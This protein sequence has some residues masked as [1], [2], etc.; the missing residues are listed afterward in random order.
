[1][2]IPDDMNDEAL[3]AV[4]PEDDGENDEKVKSDGEIAIGGKNGTD[5]SSKYKWDFENSYLIII[6]QLFR[7]LFDLQRSLICNKDLL[8]HLNPL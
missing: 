4:I 7:V 2:F 5:E 3:S 1:M 6:V 8:L